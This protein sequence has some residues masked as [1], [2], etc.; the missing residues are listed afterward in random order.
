[1]LDPQLLARLV[2]PRAWPARARDLMRVLDARARGARWPLIV[3]FLTTF[4]CTRACAYCELP[5]FGA[6]DLPDPEVRALLVD[7]CQ[8]GMRKITF[9]GGEPLLREDLPAWIHQVQATGV[10]ANLITNGDL[11]PQRVDELRAVDLVIVSL[12]G[13]EAVHDAQRGVGSYARALAGAQACR[14][15][16][17][18]LMLSAVIHQ[19]SLPHLDELLALVRELGVTAIVQPME[20]G[21]ST[22]RARAAQGVLA[23]EERRQLFA[24]LREARRRG[25]RI[26]YPRAFLRRAAR[27]DE[28]GPCRW[29]GRL[30]CTLLPDGRVA[31]CNLLTGVRP[32]WPNAREEGL[33]AALAR[34]P[35]P[36]CGGCAAGYPELDAWLSGRW[37]DLW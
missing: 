25:V 17:V 26:A 18:P 14:T 11:L 9:S 21:A 16:G 2:G 33:R 13:P 35:A 3:Q 28:P 27:G 19:A 32:D 5:D 22:G 30:F 29:A 12:D 23:P 6:E 10:F 15:A 24:R 4:R 8:S 20:F 36:N 34:L 31:P 37:W 1:M 7:A